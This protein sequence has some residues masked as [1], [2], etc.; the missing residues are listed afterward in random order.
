[1]QGAAS[2]EGHVHNYCCTWLLTWGYFVHQTSAVIKWCLKGRG[3]LLYR[4]PSPSLCARS[5]RVFVLLEEMDVPLA[6]LHVVSETSHVLSSLVKEG[7]MRM[8]MM[9]GGLHSQMRS[10][11]DFPAK[12][13]VEPSPSIGSLLTLHN[14]RPPCCQYLPQQRLQTCTKNILSQQAT[15][16]AVT[17][18]FQFPAK[19]IIGRADPFAP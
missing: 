14:P 8:M 15:I 1:M 5:C 12:R 6:R 17:G 19:K 10:D 13:P 3:T 4:P 9:I 2:F 11:I 7:Q 18:Q 16:E